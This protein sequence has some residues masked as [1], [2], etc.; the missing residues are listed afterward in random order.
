VVGVVALV[1]SVSD[2]DDTAADTGSPTT[3][4]PSDP[5]DPA[6]TVPRSTDE[7]TTPDDPFSDPTLPTLPEIPGLDPS[8]QARP[9]DEV[10]PGIIDFVERTRGHRF[11]T[12][13][14]VEPVAEDEFEARLS[15]LQGEEVD[16]LRDEGVTDVALGLV[17]P[18]TDLGDIARQ[19]GASSVLGFY[20]PDTGE[21]LVKGDEVTPLVAT[22]IAHEL[23]HA[24][25][26]QYFDLGRLDTLSERPDESAFGLL[27]V[28]EGTARYV[29]TAYRE[30][31]GPD[32]QAAL[33]AEELQLG[34]DQMLGLGD[35]PPSYL[36]ASLV[37]YGSGQRLV[38]AV[39]DRGGI[40]ALDGAIE[41]P[42]TTSEQVLE[43][44]LFIARE[45][46]VEVTFGAVDLRLLQLGADPFGSLLEAGDGVVDPV[47]G[48]GGGRYVSWDDGGRSCI[49]VVLVGDDAAGTAAVEEILDEWAA[50]IGSGGSVV[51]QPG[52]S[53]D[54]LVASRCA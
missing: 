45:A 40:T 8:E 11:R 5:V 9:L 29:E 13:P 50:G 25:D 21:L 41:R 48:F 22:I 44:D 43:P 30:Q 54:Q 27:A 28:A 12:A 36:I 6:P 16:A 34:F 26:D 19:A 42:P 49:Q 46:A 7:P 53:G 38:D 23:T 1:G 17:E 18:G 39:V 24:L 3:E 32:E 31:L 47:P 51:S 37:P 52:P 33:E 4:I 35:V 14:V 10:L 15:E 2:D 20:L